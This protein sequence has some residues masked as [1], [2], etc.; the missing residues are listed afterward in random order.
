MT[1][2]DAR[3]TASLGIAAGALSRPSVTCTTTGPDWARTTTS[4]LI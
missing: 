1:Q 4:Q 2:Q 3:H